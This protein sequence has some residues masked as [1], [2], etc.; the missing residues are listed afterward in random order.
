MCVYLQMTEIEGGVSTYWLQGY[1]AVCLYTDERSRRLCV[2]VV[3][4]RRRKPCVYLLMT[5][6][7]GRVFT[8]WKKK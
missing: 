5:E 4:D 8:N 3:M 6:V 2:Y 7:E 1:K